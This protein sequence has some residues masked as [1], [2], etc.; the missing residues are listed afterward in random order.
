MMIIFLTYSDGLSNINLSK[1]YKF[2]LKE[3]SKATVTIVKT[4]NQF[5]VV[6]FKIQSN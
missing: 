5:G 1:L 2:H 6:E 3:K 4:S